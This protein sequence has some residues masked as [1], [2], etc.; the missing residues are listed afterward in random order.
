MPRQKSKATKS[1][2]TDTLF[3]TEDQVEKILAKNLSHFESELRRLQNEITDLKSSAISITKDHE[4]TDAVKNI[5]Q[6]ITD[7]KSTSIK[8]TKDSDVLNNLQQAT[9][10]QVEQLQAKFEHFEEENRNSIG[11]MYQQLEAKAESINIIQEKTDELEQINKMSNIRIAS[12]KE[13]EG[14]D[15]QSKVINLAEKMKIRLRPT[16]IREVRRMGPVNENKTRDILVKFT[17]RRT[18]D[19]LY[20]HRKMLTHE[21]EPIYVN[22]DLTQRRSQLFYEGRKLRNQGRIFGVWSQQGNILIKVTQN[23]QPRAVSSYREIISLIEKQSNMF[24][25]NSD[26]DEEANNIE[27]NVVDSDY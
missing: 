5:Q 2:Q 6:D 13:E 20:Q 15:V 1:C 16:D 9:E 24:P 3:L 18:R 7:L 27:D 11:K 22:E 4:D 8:L 14:E 12:L 21:T 19:D 10:I 23:C 26:C 17:S 25:T